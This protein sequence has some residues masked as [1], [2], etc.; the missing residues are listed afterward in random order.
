MLLDEDILRGE[1][2]DSQCQRSSHAP[3]LIS[4]R[5]RA[6][7][8]FTWAARV[9]RS[10]QRCALYHWTEA[11]GCPGQRPMNTGFPPTSRTMH[12]TVDFSPKA[13]GTVSVAITNRETRASK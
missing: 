4:N 7:C 6:N 11:S 1:V 5:A 2:V 12:Y 8:A 9:L 10:M 13:A 3:Q